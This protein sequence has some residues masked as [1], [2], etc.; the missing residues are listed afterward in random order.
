ML[1][2]MLQGTARQWL[3]PLR[4]L[5]SRVI[6]ASHDLLWLAGNRHQIPP[7]DQNINVSYSDLKIALVKQDVHPNLYCCRPTSSALDAL[8]SSVK[9]TGP[10]A[11]FTKTNC[12]FFIVHTTTEP[13]CQIWQQ[14]WTNCRQLPIET[15]LENSSNGVPYGGGGELVPQ[16]S[17]AVKVD[18]ISWS[19]FD[20]VISIDIAIPKRIVQENKQALWCYYISEPC[21]S[22]YRSSRMAPLAGYDVFLNQR[23]GPKRSNQKWHEINF[24][25]N[26]QYYRIFHEILGLSKD[27]QRE[28]IF[29]ETATSR[30]LRSKHRSRLTKLGSLRSVSPFTDQIVRDLCHSKIFVQLLGNRRLWGNGV[31]E[32]VAA[33]CPAV[34]RPGSLRNTNLIVAGSYALTDAGVVDLVYRALTNDKLLSSI[35]KRQQDALDYYCFHLPMRELVQR[36]Q[37][38][39]K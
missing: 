33:G 5:A 3:R 23:I 2:P 17:V 32:A 6:G 14:K 30:L 39:R 13:E 21:M 19:S 22:S 38:K 1:T 9:H 10:L 37:S 26:L 28:G 34:C 4:P 11:L 35:K 36:L 24:P 8:H 7:Y 20:I 16:A 15:Y 27:D 12:T 29:I 31:I 18:D 25:Y